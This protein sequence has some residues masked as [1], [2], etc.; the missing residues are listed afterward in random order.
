MSDRPENRFLACPNKYVITFVR[1][2]TVGPEPQ[3]GLPILRKMIKLITS[4]TPVVSDSMH[5]I[6]T[7]AKVYIGTIELVSTQTGS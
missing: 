3:Q 5:L 1:I 7:M 6:G 4:S 2:A